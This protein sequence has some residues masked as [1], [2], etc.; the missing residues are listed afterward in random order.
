MNR[1]WKNCNLDGRKYL[2]G[3]KEIF[4][5]LIECFISV[6]KVSG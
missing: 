2:I 6:N 3:F 5:E 4:N 1:L